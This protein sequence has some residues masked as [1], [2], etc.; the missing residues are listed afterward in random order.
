MS[1]PTF[2]TNTIALTGSCVTLLSKWMAYFG[3]K[4]ATELLEGQ[5]VMIGCTHSNAQQLEAALRC[6]THYTTLSITQIINYIGRGKRNLQIDIYS[7][8]L[9][10]KAS[11]MSSIA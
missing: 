2:T 3:Y 7:T 11:Q 10:S 4:R 1:C 8:Q 6:V 9:V 5:S